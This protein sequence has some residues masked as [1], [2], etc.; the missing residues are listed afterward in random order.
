MNL[1][2]RSGDSQADRMTW[3]SASDL[4]PGPALLAM[5]GDLAGHAPLGQH[6]P[7]RLEIVAGIQVHH[8][9][10]TA[11]SQVPAPFIG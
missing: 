2:N 8:R 3:T 7:A 6:L 11:R 4:P 1:G 9:P 5:G 10:L